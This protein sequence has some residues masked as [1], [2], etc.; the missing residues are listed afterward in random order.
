MTTIA[1]RDGIIAF[2]TLITADE[3]VFST[4]DKAF[5]INDYIVGCAGNLTDIEKFLNWVKS[6][7]PEEKPK[8]SIEAIL[9][10]GNK[11]NIVSDNCVFSKMAGKF[12]AIGTGANYA[13]GAMEMGATAKQAVAI[14]RKYDRL[15]G[16]KIKEIKI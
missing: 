5:K 7:M 4:K 10:K 6:D 8:I 15:T 16:R 13:L 11:V 12:C 9:I 1:F 2:D 14:A 3:K